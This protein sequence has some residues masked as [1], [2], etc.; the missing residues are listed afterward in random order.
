VEIFQL[1]NSSFVFCVGASGV[2]KLFHDG[3]LKKMAQANERPIIFALYNPS[4]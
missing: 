1:E 3:V 4:Y 2:G